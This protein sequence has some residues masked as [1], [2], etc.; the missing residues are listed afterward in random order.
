MNVQAWELWKEG[1][2]TELKD[3][4]LEDQSATTQIGRCIHVGLLCIQNDAAKRPTMSEVVAMITHETLPLP[5]PKK[6][7][8]VFTRQKLKEIKLESSSGRK[9]DFC[10]INEASISEMEPR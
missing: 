7:A 10:S 6:P 3:S 1:R 2:S 5:N 4:T 8:A 9:Q